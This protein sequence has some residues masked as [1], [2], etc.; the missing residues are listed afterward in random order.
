MGVDLKSAEQMPMHYALA[1]LSEKT[2]LTQK[3]K[4]KLERERQNNTHAPTRPSAPN[5]NSKT[6]TF[7]STK[8]VCG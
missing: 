5:T 1:F 6:K 7:V 3:V 8:R 2:A 4:S